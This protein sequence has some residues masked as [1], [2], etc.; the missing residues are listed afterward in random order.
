MSV[1]VIVLGAAVT[2]IVCAS[3]MMVDVEIEVMVNVW[4]SAVVVEMEVEVMV[5]T[6]VSVL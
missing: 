1:T 3:G 2:V 5:A 4:G 6:S